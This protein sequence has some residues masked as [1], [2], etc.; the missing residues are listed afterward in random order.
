MTQYELVVGL[1]IHA[2]L[3]TQSKMFC[4]CANDYFAA[5][6]NTRVC[7]VCLGLPGALPVINEKAVRNTVLTGLALNCTIPSFAKFDR[8][9]YFYPD[10]VKNY[11]ISQYDL[12]LCLDGWMDVE[13]SV[14][15]TVGTRRL[16]ITRVHLEEDTGKLTHV[17]RGGEEY[18]LIDYNR[19]GVPLM[20]IVS[21]HDMHTVD[22]VNQYIHRIHGLLRHLGVSTGDMEK[23]AMRFEANI[24]LNPM[25]SGVLGNRV[26]V[27]NLNSFR[28]V[29]HSI[30]YEM[31]RQAGILDGGGAVQQETM[32]W[33][34]AAGVTVSQRGKEDAHDY[35]YFPEPDLPP[36]ALSRE[37]V[38]QVRASMPEL[39]D[40]KRE[41]FMVSLGLSRYDASL[42]AEDQGVA[43]YF[44]TALAAARPDEVK[45]IA[46]WI[47]GEMFRLM[48]ERKT[49]IGD[50]KIAPA[51]L[52]ELV[53]LVSDGA[54][55]NSMAKEVFAEMFAT[56][57]AA[58]LIVSERGLSQISD[59]DALAAIVAGVMKAN[60]QAVADYRAGKEAA[61]S[62]LVGQV[63]KASRG[64]ANPALAGRLLQE[65]LTREA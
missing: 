49:E 43:A 62:F 4:R 64:R 40:A 20:E 52:V 16:R 19:S 34:E 53:R 24:S 35:R 63:M 37:W 30:E 42:L 32:G 50:V 33:D 46:N 15:T 13:T 6:P 3:L 36:L 27:K 39:P 29:I 21:Y 45:T 55:S 56:G 22:E 47:L 59:T 11:Q 26:E 17:S 7:P 31:Q 2:Q 8:K 18:S 44:E 5:E 12:P 9:N 10:L 57:K 38:E 51:A 60:P 25:G 61:L 23:G 58:S 54:I 48:P 1:E 65:A 41:R 28:A 14:G